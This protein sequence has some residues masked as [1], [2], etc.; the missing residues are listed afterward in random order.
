MKSCIGDLNRLKANT[1]RASASE[2]LSFRL[3][4]DVSRCWRLYTTSGT[5]GAG[6]VV[7]TQEGSVLNA[8]SLGSSLIVRKSYFSLKYHCLGG[9]KNSFNSGCWVEKIIS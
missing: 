9:K 6:A 8:L 5:L 4:G 7:I 3:G 1:L 2:G